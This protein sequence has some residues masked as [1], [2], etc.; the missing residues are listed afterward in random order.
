MTLKHPCVALGHARPRRGRVREERLRQ[1]VGE[2]LRRRWLA[3][4]DDPMVALVLLV[5]ERPLAQVAHA[6]LRGSNSRQCDAR[7]P[8][9][10]IYLRAIAATTRDSGRRPMVAADRCD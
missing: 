7:A 4:L 8:A 2:D 1:R 3:V 9:W 10:R 6:V 5:P